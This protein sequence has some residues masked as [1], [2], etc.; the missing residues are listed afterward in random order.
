MGPLVWLLIA[1]TGVCLHAAALHGLRALRQR[2][3]L[4]AR[5]ALLGLAVAVYVG[6][7][8]FSLQAV[9]AEAFRLALRVG[10]FGLLATAALLAL[11]VRAFAGGRSPLPRILLGLALL[12]GLAELLWPGGLLRLYEVPVRS[13]SLPWGETV[14][15]L[16]HTG[17]PGHWLSNALLLTAV[18]SALRDLHQP[19]LLPSE[20]LRVARVALWWVLGVVALITLG[21]AAGL[22]DMIVALAPAFVISMISLAYA[23]R[24][25]ERR[26]AVTERQR[27][28]RQLRRLTAQLALGEWRPPPDASEAEALPDLADAA[29]EL[30]GVGRVSFW[31]LEGENRL[32]SL[33]IHDRRG[34]AHEEPQ[35]FDT[36]QCA[37]YLQR[38]RKE[39][40]IVADNAPGD[41]RLV[42]TDAPYLRA[43]GIQAS[44][45]LA[46]RSGGRMV[47]LLCIGSLAGPRHWSDEDVAFGNALALLAGARWAAIRQTRSSALL[48]SLAAASSDGEAFFG[49]A[50]REL[51][52]LLN[53]D[54]AFIALTEADG[55]HAQTLALWK[56]GRLSP[57]PLRYALPGSPCARVLQGRPCGY[58]HGVAAQFPEDAL[59]AELGIEGYVGAPLGGAE[60]T[61]AGLVVALRRRPLLLDEDSHHAMQ[62]VA[63]RVGA[64]LERQQNEARR[65]RLAFSD[66]LTGLPTRIALAEVI[67][68][69]I[70]ECREQGGSAALLIADIDHFQTINDALGHDVGD[71]VLRRMARTLEAETRPGEFIARMTGDEFAL[72]LPVAANCDDAALLDR[73]NALRHGLETPP[74]SGDN[75]LSLGTSVGV[76]VFDAAT[77]SANDVLR[78][79]EMALRQAKSTGRGRAALYRP[80]LEAA[81]TRRLV[82]HEALRQAES[83]GELALVVQPKVDRAGRLAGGESLLRWNHP[84]LGA[85]APGEFIPAAESTGLITGIGQ[86]ALRETCRLLV[87]LPDWARARPGFSLAVNLSA[88]QL[89]RPDIVGEVLATVRAENALPSQLTLEITE[90]IALHDLDEV[91][92]KLKA[93]RAAGFHISLDDFGTGYS[94][95]AYLHRLP[96]DELKIDRSFVVEAMANPTQSLLQPLIALGRHRG[97]VVVAEGIETAEQA[98]HL[99][100]LGCDLFQGYGFA[101]PLAGEAFLDWVRARAPMP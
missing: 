8:S 12:L 61:P 59:L 84:V 29:R 39:G 32:R 68:R 79:A 87:R 11:G 56:D 67:G 92:G 47:G 17:A 76:A 89:A 66:L 9:D 53:A 95:L 74:N 31:R 35:L 33:L 5:M 24:R 26:E 3:G 94:S 51:A 70:D 27:A 69:R 44:L 86:W 81:S 57:D 45:D 55:S 36:G 19:G 37:D 82:L 40:L 65:R 38:L 75:R 13:L 100:A 20:S 34:P 15:M 23:I 54:I 101:P 78:H 43:Q 18:L 77:P 1:V 2:E 71:A 25:H 42:E 22:A 58:A 99:A 4:H 21:R 16:Q 97:L 64:E 49:L 52:H 93:L 96:L 48:Q 98:E 73:A 80:S 10:Y 30:L 46:I 7:L 28:A 14:S 91:I 63:Q 41:A 62:L 60:G 50:V 83:R 90:S 88:W 85:V 72:L 6:G